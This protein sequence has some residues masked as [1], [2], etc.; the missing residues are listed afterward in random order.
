[1]AHVSK[2]ASIYDRH[3]RK[4]LPRNALTLDTALAP[5]LALKPVER[6]EDET[7]QFG[8]LSKESTGDGH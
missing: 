4:I 2:A 3:L 5:Q 6:G 7:R 8:V 1:M